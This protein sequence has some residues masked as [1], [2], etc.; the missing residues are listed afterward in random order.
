M[1][2]PD[3]AAASPGIPPRIAARGRLRMWTI[4]LTS[5]L[6]FLAP[7]VVAPGL[8]ALQADFAHMENAELLSR[9]V[10]TMPMLFIALSGPFV[11]YVIDRFGRKNVLIICAAAYGA[12]GISV[13][14]L[15][16]L[17]A[18]LVSR[19]ILGVFLAGILTSVTAL[20]GDYYAGD[21]RNRIA[22]L[23][24]AFMS[25]GTLTFVV[26]SGLLAEIHWRVSFSL[27]AVA[28]ALIPL[29]LL[30]LYEPMSASPAGRSREP[31]PTLRQ[32]GAIGFVCGLTFLTLVA[33]FMIPSQT[34]F[35]LVEIG[36]SDPTRAGIAIGMFNLTAGF[37]SLAF[38]RIRKRLSPEAIF[39]LI[40]AFGGTGFVMTGHAESFT[41]TLVAM[42]VGGFSMGA[43][44][45]NANMA[46]ISRASMG[47]RGRAL[48]ALTTL[49]FLGQFFSPV[50]SVPVAAG[51]SV[52]F[53]FEVTG[54]W[55]LAISAAFA[56]YATKGG[57]RAA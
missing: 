15:E 54:F 45:P 2:G 5:G 3:A 51:G 48:G 37:A 25:F 46:I 11:G 13:L 47:V 4:L 57:W 41:Q 31:R 56:L 33:M 27:F 40:F 29:M 9:M 18:I 49:F 17:V 34:Q 14:L 22:G 44:I 43:F 20:L 8:P 50:Y 26:I 36:V 53:A 7:S 21:E 24:G 28:F 16:S 19:A 1:S 35:F 10:L 38:G 23:Q 42:A 32:W 39:A 30:S 55:L 6:A 12:A 52:A